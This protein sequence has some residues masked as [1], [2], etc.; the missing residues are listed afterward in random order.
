MNFNELM[1][2]LYAGSKDSLYT[3][4]TDKVE[5]N[6]HFLAPGWNY[7][8]HRQALQGFPDTSQV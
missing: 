6:C 8:T 3:A 2:T 5:R 7:M 4:N 1:T